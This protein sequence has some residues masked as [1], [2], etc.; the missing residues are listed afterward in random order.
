MSL[1][2]VGDIHGQYDELMK[3]MDAMS[4]TSEDTVV[5]LG[6]YIDRGPKS[7]E[8][9][10]QL[11]KWKQEFPHWQFLFGNHEQLFLDYHMQNGLRFGQ[12]CW[13]QNGGDVTRDSYKPAQLSDYEKAIFQFEMPKEHVDFIVGLD[14]WYETEDYFFVHGGIIPEEPIDA[15]KDYPDTMLW[16]RDGFINSDWNWG[17]KI[18]FGH[19]PAYRKEWGKIGYPIVKENKI[20]LDGAVCPP[21]NHALLAA[22]LTDNTC[23]R[24]QTNSLKLQTFDIY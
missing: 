7:P 18:I 8:V 3:I 20:G 13:L 21:G 9:L 23:Y 5:F 1:Y 11:I 2:A 6:D 24:V 17:K 4:P 15:S 14:L 12:Y 22:N 19:T 10:E 16:A